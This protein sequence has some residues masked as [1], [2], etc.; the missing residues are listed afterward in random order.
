MTFSPSPL[1]QVASKTVLPKGDIY[2]LIAIDWAKARNNCRVCRIYGQNSSF[3]SFFFFRG[4]MSGI[5]P[6]HFYFWAYCDEAKLGKLMVGNQSMS[7]LLNMN[8]KLSFC[9]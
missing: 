4:S 5:F 3:I 7:Y 1:F 6:A 8:S 2:I 9:I